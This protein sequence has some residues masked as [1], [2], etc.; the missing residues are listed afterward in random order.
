[1]TSGG[2]LRFFTNTYDKIT[3]K[4]VGGSYRLTGDNIKDFETIK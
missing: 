4:T 1:M 2:S 3:N